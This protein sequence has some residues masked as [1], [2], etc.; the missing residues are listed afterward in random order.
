MR[1]TALQCV[2]IGCQGPN[3]NVAITNATVIVNAH[4][5]DVLIAG[6]PESVSCLHASRFMG[7][8]NIGPTSN[9]QTGR[10]RLE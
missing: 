10:R 2:R 4:V 5:I 6:P 7:R 3:T 1:M 8:V 9:G